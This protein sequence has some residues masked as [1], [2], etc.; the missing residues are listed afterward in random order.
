VAC[1]NQGEGAP[2]RTDVHCL[3]QAIQHQN[4]TV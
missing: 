3:P 1:I 4:V 2:R